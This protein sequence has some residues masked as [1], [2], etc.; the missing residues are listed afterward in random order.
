MEPNNTQN[1]SSTHDP[2]DV[3]AAFAAFLRTFH[4]FLIRQCHQT[5]RETPPTTE[6]GTNTEEAQIPGSSSSITFP[7]T[8]AANQTENESHCNNTRIE[9]SPTNSLP[10]VEENIETMEAPQEY[11][12]TATEQTSGNSQA[13][14]P[15]QVS[16]V[17]VPNAH[18]RKSTRGKKKT[19]ICVLAACK[20]FRLEEEVS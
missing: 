20:K 14:S 19:T 18:T 5:R 7:V 17:A 16:A 12:P 15:A 2:E 6:N 3:L 9:A 1:T 4:L 11:R 8:S 10:E 13:A